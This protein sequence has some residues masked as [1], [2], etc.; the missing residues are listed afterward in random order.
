MEMG[1]NICPYCGIPLGTGNLI[2][3]EC[4]ELKPA[5]LSLRSWAIYNGPIREAIHRLKYKGDFGLADTLSEF[6]IK[7]IADL[8]WDIDMI[9]PVPLS[10][11]R[12]DERGY[13]QAALIGFP[14]GLFF[15]YAYRPNGLKRIR[16][17][18]SQVGLSR[19]ER[20][21]NV[22]NAFEADPKVVAGK[23]I[24]VVDDVCTTGSTIRACAEAL[25]SAGAAAVYAITVA[26][27][28]PG[29]TDK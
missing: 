5:Y 4:Q 14:I 23:S 27:A 15:N 29:Y 9:I 25:V 12:K 7:E 8:K 13:N 6:L 1:E 16:E 21:I 3:P 11:G 28:I 19:E 2:C 17:T 10:S 22:K 26:R 20:L 18:I 24:L